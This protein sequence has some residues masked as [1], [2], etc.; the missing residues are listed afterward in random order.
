MLVFF[1][2]WFL[3][4]WSRLR[5]DCYSPQVKLASAY[6]SLRKYTTICQKRWTVG[7]RDQGGQ[8]FLFRTSTFVVTSLEPFTYDSYTNPAAWWILLSCI[9]D[10]ADTKK[11][12]NCGNLWVSKDHFS[13]VLVPVWSCL[14]S[15][16]LIRTNSFLPHNDFVFRSEPATKTRLATLQMAQNEKNRRKSIVCIWV[17]NEVMN[18]PPDHSGSTATG[19]TAL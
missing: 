16:C 19:L 14:T 8:T 12:S 6:N 1:G 10:R 15:A 7:L 11:T 2:S 5:R 4:F 9:S 3:L 17:W 18:S 13:P